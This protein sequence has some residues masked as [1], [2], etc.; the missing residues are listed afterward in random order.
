MTNKNESELVAEFKAL[1]KKLIETLKLK[2]IK[3]GD[4]DANSTVKK[5]IKSYIKKVEEAKELLKKYE[6]VALKINELANEK[7]EP[8][9]EVAK[10]VVKLRKEPK[11]KSAEIEILEEN[12]DKNKKA[13]T[14]VE[15][16]NGKPVSKIRK[17]KK[18]FSSQEF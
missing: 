7:V 15:I 16:E 14:V 8:S 17:K 2:P 12:K 18:D 5:N 11:I 1:E 3:V 10:A 4:E 6:E 9:E 13:E